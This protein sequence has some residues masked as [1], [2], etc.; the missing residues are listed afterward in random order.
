M[1]INRPEDLGD[2]A[3]LGLTLAEGKLL[4]ADLQQQIVA[5]QAKGPRRSAA[6]LPKLWRRLPREGLFANCLV[7]TML[8]LI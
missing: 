8:G 5:A 2:V 3:N 4:L 1:K 7:W 6:G